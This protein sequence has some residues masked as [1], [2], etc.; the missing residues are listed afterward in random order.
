VRKSKKWAYS[1]NDLF[2]WYFKGSP[3]RDGATGP[4][5]QPGPVG[6]SGA[7][8]SPGLPGAPGP[9]VSKIEQFVF[10]SCYGTVSL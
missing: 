3:G 8:G 6:D 7:P 10:I 9:Q 5:G 4:M 2:F 1:D